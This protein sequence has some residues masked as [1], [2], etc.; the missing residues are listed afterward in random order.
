M[1][2][3]GDH[4]IPGRLDTKIK[5]TSAREEGDRDRT[6]CHASQDG[7]TQWQKRHDAPNGTNGVG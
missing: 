2:H 1:L 7:M 5:S 6:V 4:P 3:R